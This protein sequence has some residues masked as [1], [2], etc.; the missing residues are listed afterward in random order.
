MGE[1]GAGRAARNPVASAPGGL[2]SSVAARRLRQSGP[3]ILPQPR[4]PAAWRRL[5]AQLVHF[6]ALMLWVA[7]ALA[8]VAG[9]TELAVAICLVVVINGCFAFAQ[10]ARAEHAA[11]RLQDLLPR[12]CVVSRDGV[13]RE[14]DATELVVG[15]L[16][17]L[18]AGD[19]ISADLVV[20]R[21]DGL[22]IDTSMLTGESVPASVGLD[23]ML[24]AGTFVVEGEG[25]AVVTATAGSTRLGS[26]AQLTRGENR[27]RGTLARELDHVVRVI[28]TVAVACGLAFFGIAMLV[29]TP[30]TDGFL[31][32]IGVTVAL[33]PEG[34][35]PTVTLSLAIG[36]QRMSRR[37]ALVR[38]LESVETLGSTTFICTDKTGTLTRNE[39]S[40]VEVWT[41]AGSVGI[42][43]DGYE[44]TATVSGAPEAVRSAVA[45][46]AAGARCS[47]GRAVEHDQRWVAQ[48]DPMEAALDVLA[49]RLGTAPRPGVERARF[50]FDPRRRRMSVVVDDWVLVKG[51]PDSVLA[52]CESVAGAH[53]ALD[54][55]AARGLRVLAVAVREFGTNALADADAAEQ[56]L[57]LL[58]L[59]GFED[60]PRTSAA[61]ALAACRRA[62]INVAMVTG[63]HPATAVAIAREVGLV[64]GQPRV[65]LGRD[66]P[67]DEAVLGALV[68]HDGVVIARVSPEDKLRIAHALRARGHVL[69][70]TGDGVNDG[71]ALQAADIGIAMGS[72]GTDVAREAADLVLL[73]D[74]F[75]TIV[76]AV[77]QGRATFGNIRKFL[78]YH[79][80]DN[81]A[82]LTPFVVWALS[83]GR[84]PLALTVLQVLCLDIGTDLLP[85]LALGAEAPNPHALDGPPIRGR[86]MDRHLFRRAFG[87]L[88]PTEAFVEMAAFLGTY[89]AM[90][91]RPG[92]ALAGG[93]LLAA[94][95]AAFAAV[96]LGQMAN[97]FACRSSSRRPGQLG[98]RSNRLLL[99]SVAIEGLALL[100]FLGIPSLADLLRHAPPTWVG[101]GIAI[102][103]IP[104]L[105]GVDALDKFRRSRHEL[106]AVQ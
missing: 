85:A 61:P 95:G 6:F 78:T 18:N 50:S 69:A 87:V 17:V 55:M 5:G 40:V 80:T 44:P 99:A 53:D 106:G 89:L 30:G 72:S 38:R 27:P 2:T 98:W 103:A 9:L 25:R 47:S 58:G 96:V 26:I 14:I 66:L 100:A 105:L 32:A 24:Y 11:Q 41:P 90:G 49:R 65:I 36:A 15:D 91:W 74:D 21:A 79:L 48:G 71:P 67:D 68:D 97:A 10:E 23:A 75:A 46:A 64:R 37:A 81:V 42:T 62:G 35:L 4:P 73:D 57:M 82:E 104:A 86:L 88:G 39:M 63:D 51:A 33:V 70:M 93:P 56:E 94:S 3:N 16:V 28:A 84:F 54:A 20:V 43:G 102:L 8:F 77:E 7:A 31:F 92:D 13:E 29:G 12:R 59:A 34:L 1:I 60:P 45:F 76:S 19:R 101:A 83:G 22:A 52:V